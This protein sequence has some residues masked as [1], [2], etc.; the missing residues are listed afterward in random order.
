MRL[1]VFESE[2]AEALCSYGV[3]A[4]LSADRYAKN[5]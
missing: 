4:E 1:P 5:G 3:V 2:S